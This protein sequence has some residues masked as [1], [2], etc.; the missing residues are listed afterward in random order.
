MS[1]KI[2]ELT[3]AKEVWV[4]RYKLALSKTNTEENK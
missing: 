3:G 1:T 2:I 4:V